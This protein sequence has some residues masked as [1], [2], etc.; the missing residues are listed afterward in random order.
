MPPAPSFAGLCEKD[1]SNP[2]IDLT[3]LSVRE[4]LWPEDA[5]TLEAIRRTVFIEEQGVPKAIEWDGQEEQARHV[6]AEYQG[7]AIGCGRL[8]EDGRIG[9]LAVLPKWR[10]QGIGERLLRMLLTLAQQRGDTAVYLHA[11]ADAVDFY[12]RA[13]FSAV[14]EPFDE[15]GIRHQD[16][17]LALD[18]STWDQTIVRLNY[19]RPFDQLVVAQAALARR[20]LRILSPNLDP[21]VFEQEALFSALRALLRKG[22]MSQIK[23]LVQDARGISRRGHGLLNLARRLPSGITLKRLAEHSDW[24]GDT[25]VIRDRDSLL[26]LPGGDLDPGFYRPD[27]RARSETALGRFEELWRVADVDPEFRSLAL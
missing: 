6:I 17:H 26:A 23:V 14:G 24:S 19:P 13:G 4:G 16:M 21:L 18:Y 9:R 8:L 5:T 1:V 7:D 27:D 25:Q 10:S 22:R 20:E 15:A 11:Q 12:A 3:H 2:M